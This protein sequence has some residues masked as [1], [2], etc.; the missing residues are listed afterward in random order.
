MGTFNVE[1]VHKS[2]VVSK[3][4]VHVAVMAPYHQITIKYKMYIITVLSFP[5]K[6]QII[7]YSLQLIQT[8]Q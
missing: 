2:V 5:F 4:M 7:S 6:L 3:F 8:I 1:V